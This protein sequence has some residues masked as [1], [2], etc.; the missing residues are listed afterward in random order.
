MKIA[1]PE[2]RLLASAVEGD[3]DSVDALLRAI[4][5]GVFNLAVRMLGNRDDAS[6]AAQ[7]ILLKVVTHLASFRGDS[8][9]ATWV[10]RV[11]RNHLLTALTRSREAPEV[12]LE[13]LAARLQ[14][15]LDFGASLAFDGPGTPLTP[16]D[17]LAARQV[18]ISCTQGMLMALDREQRLAWLLDTVFGLSA[19]AGA[20]VLGIAPAAYRQRLSR[21][22]RALDPFVTRTCGLVSDEAPCHC[23][24]QLPAIRQLDAQTLTRRSIPLVAI[25]RRELGDAERQ[26]AALVRMSDAA[27]LFRAHPE[28]SAPA[29]MVEGIRDVLRL[30][31]YWRPEDRP[32]LQ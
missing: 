24:R 23:E 12:S 27:A 29:T 31:G 5:P 21:A 32:S 11:A 3:L 25:G 30:E 20:Q 1:E 26:F 16:E 2:P 9:F 19:D 14:A 4:Q 13:G 6:D 22:R 8:A 18:A 15:G 10:F 7:E 17:K 28:Y